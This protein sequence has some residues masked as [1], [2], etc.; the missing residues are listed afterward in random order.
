[1]FTGIVE[2]IGTVVEISP[3]GDGIHCRIEAPESI[4]KELKEG[5]SIALNGACSTALSPEKNTFQVQFLKETLEKTH[6]DTLKPGDALNLEL[7]LTPQS[8]IGGHFVTGHIDE[9]G[10][11]VTLKIEDPWAK[12]TIGYSAQFR[13]LLLPKGSITVNGIALTL[14]EITEKE[15]T[16]HIIPHTLT[17]TTLRQLKSG[18]KVNLEYD[19]LGKYL[20]NFVTYGEKND[21]PFLQI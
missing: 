1:M 2:A 13:P 20:Y 12:L 3:L 4:V 6:F 9:T 10:T 7:S 15:F 5:D 18:E 21:T 19:I 16:C 8:R 11:V 14:V 17:Q